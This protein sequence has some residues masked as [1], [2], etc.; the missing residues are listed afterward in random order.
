VRVAGR[1]IALWV[2]ARDSRPAVN[3]VL[4]ALLKE[5]E[6]AGATVEVVVPETRIVDAGDPA[7]A[8]GADLVL[9]KSATTFALSCAT[10]VEA[11]GVRSLNA[12]RATLRANDKAAVIARLAAAGVPVPRTYL[13]ATTTAAAGDEAGA[14]VSKPTRGVHGR[15]VLRSPTFAGARD[16]PA[17]DD[18][19]PVLVVD[20][21]TRLL[22]PWIGGA[23]VDTKVY[24]AGEECFAGAKAFDATSFASDEIATTALDETTAAIVRAAG[25]ALDLRCYGIDLRWEDG[26]AIVVDANP[27]PGYRG[28]LAAVPALLAEIERAL[29]WS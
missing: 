4:R 1:R 9:L 23:S 15:G 7:R 19:G 5:C 26:R 6:A 24:V 16:A 29:A 22:Q 27:F 3:P 18:A 12:A 14:W 11:A 8:L 2:E 17:V 10:A 21:G 25:E 28:F 13:S 20:D